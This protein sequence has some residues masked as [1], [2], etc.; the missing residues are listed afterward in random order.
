MRRALFI[1]AAVLPLAVGVVNFAAPE[2][3]HRNL[4]NRTYEGV[5]IRTGDRRADSLDIT[6]TAVDRDEAGRVLGSRRYL[7]LQTDAPRSV[8]VQVVDEDGRVVS[9]GG[10]ELK[11]SFD[12]RP[13]DG[14]LAVLEVLVRVKNNR[15]I[16]PPDETPAAR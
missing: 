3:V 12:L 9:V 15:E 1:L 5:R 4:V 11:G 7:R 2:R 13:H 8:A 14:R 10:T 16:P 6:R